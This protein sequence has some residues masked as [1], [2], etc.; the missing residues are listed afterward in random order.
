MWQ[1]VDDY[2]HQ[3]RSL[4]GTGT[5]ALPAPANP[6]PTGPLTPHTWTGPAATTAT[7][8]TQTLGNTRG[9][10]TT[11]QSH[12]D[13]QLT[14]AA[15]ISRTA[16]RALN[17]IQTSWESDKAAL[18]PFANTPEG[19]SALNRR[20]ISASPKP[21]PWSTTPQPDTGQPPPTSAPP[22][23]GSHHRRPQR[24]PDPDDDPT[25]RPDTQ[26]RPARRPDPR[27][28]RQPA[29]HPRPRPAAAHHRFPTRQRD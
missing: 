6:P 18:G 12:T 4:L 21:K 27:R 2:L 13:H 17:A 16:H 26:T 9:Q 20:A 3:A 23:S 19:Q 7:A 22:S 15:D 25:R 14:A 10:L 11:A 28:R 1:L 29:T 8:T 5:P 24:H